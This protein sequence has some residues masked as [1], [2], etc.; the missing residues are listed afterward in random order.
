ME[1]GTTGTNL[2]IM[3]DFNIHV[4]NLDNSDASQFNDVCM[5]IGL[6]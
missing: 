3:D 2:I 6:E 5:A 4:D 1:L